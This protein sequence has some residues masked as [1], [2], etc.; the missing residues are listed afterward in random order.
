MRKNRV[1]ELVQLWGE[2]AALSIA[3]FH[4]YESTKK[5]QEKWLRGFS[6]YR[7]TREGRNHKTMETMF[8]EE[9]NIRCHGLGIRL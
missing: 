3:L 2:E 5:G 1:T 6:A 7:A 8:N 4:Y 9:D